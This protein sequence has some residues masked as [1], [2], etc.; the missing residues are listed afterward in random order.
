MKRMVVLVN[1]T[2][3]PVGVELLKQACRT[4]LAPDGAEETIIQHINENRADGI[5]TRVERITQRILESC[6]SW[7]LWASTGW[8][9][10]ISMWLPPPSMACW[11]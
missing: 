1:P 7:P 6:P 11:C 3:Q 2:I 5:V 10:T 8:G 4:V 9:S